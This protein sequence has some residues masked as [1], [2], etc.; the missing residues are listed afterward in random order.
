[1]DGPVIRSAGCWDKHAWNPRSDHSRGRACDLFATSPGTF[2]E[3]SELDAGWRMAD[4]F[5]SNAEPLQVRYLIWQ[6]RYWDPRVQDQPDGW[7][8]RY[9]GGG[10][11]ASATPPAATSTTCTSASGSDAVTR[12]RTPL[13]AALAVTAVAL[14]A[15]LLTGFAGR[16]DEPPS[17]DPPPGAVLSQDDR[18]ALDAAPVQRGAPAPPA[19][20]DVDLTDPDAVARAY[21]AAAHSVRPDDAGRTHLR[22]AAYAEPGSPPASVGVVVV[23]PP[24]PGSAR[25]AT[26]TALELA[27]VDYGNRRRGYRAELGTATGPPG[28]T[29]VVGLVERY[30][31][32]ARQ[33]DDRWLVVGDSPDLP[34][35]ED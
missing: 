17:G 21:L 2:A 23:D 20:P 28:G 5:R 10:V 32:L 4:W 31:V 18:A 13:L 15:V 29:L 24:P 3:G 9:T 11:Y 30:V 7:G 14:G 35:G 26:V 22:G 8:R 27:A 19:D 34:T 6:G 25:T 16:A 33:P 12:L 1:M